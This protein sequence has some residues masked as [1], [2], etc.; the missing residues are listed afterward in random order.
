MIPEIDSCWRAL[1]IASARRGATLSCRML[2][3][4]ASSVTIELEI[5]RNSKSLMFRIPSGAFNEVW[6]PNT[7]CVAHAWM[8]CAPNSANFSTLLCN[9]VP[10]LTISSTRMHRRPQTLPTTTTKGNPHKTRDWSQWDT[11]LEAA[12]PG[13]SPISDENHTWIVLSF[14]SSL[15]S[16]RDEREFYLPSTEALED[17]SKQGSPFDLTF[18]S[19]HHCHLWIIRVIFAIGNPTLRRLHRQKLLVEV[20]SRNRN[21]D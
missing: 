9:V 16:L 5:K 3:G 18:V 12:F 20:G 8:D 14:S 4:N 13:N 11:R 10:V 6:G 15:S 1:A 21:W 19:S 7:P 2:D 17:I